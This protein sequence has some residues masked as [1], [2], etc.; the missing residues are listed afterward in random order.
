MKGGL[1]YVLYASKINL[2][3][4][5]LHNLGD[6]ILF[7]RERSSLTDYLCL[8]KLNKQTFY[9][10]YIWWTLPFWFKLCSGDLTFL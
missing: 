6:N 4:D 7:R 3:K 5:A 9:F 1:L 2:L 8:N 10:V